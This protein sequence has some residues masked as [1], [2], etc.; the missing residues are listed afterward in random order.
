MTSHSAFYDNQVHFIQSVQRISKKLHPLNKEG[1]EAFV[2]IG[3]QILKA[4]IAGEVM[5]LFGV[6]KGEKC[7]EEANLSKAYKLDTKE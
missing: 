6:L 3:Q 4:K 5:V 7:I 2:A 1:K